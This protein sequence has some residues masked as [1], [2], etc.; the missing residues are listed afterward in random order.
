MIELKETDR[1]IFYIELNGA[2]IH[3]GIYIREEA[4]SWLDKYQ[5]VFDA[6][7]KAGYDEHEE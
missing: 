2:C 6:A 7:F 5:N 4:L 3:G 1:G